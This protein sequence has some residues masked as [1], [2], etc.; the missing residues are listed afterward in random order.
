MYGDGVNIAARL[1]QIAEPGGISLSGK[2]YEEVR[3]KLPYSFEDQ[4]E[5]QVKNVARPVRVYRF[6]T[7]PMALV[8][9]VCGRL[10]P[11][12]TGLPWRSCPS[13]T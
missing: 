3:D 9:P 13:R 12:L 2:V 8:P 6:Q 11:F 10:C 5:K 1:K 4:G 7:D